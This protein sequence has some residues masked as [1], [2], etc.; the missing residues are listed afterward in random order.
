MHVER[1]NAGPLMV[2]ELPDGSRVIVDRTNETVFALNAMAAAAWDACSAP[3]T[4]AN[5]TDSMR[6][7]FDPLTTEELAQEAIFQLREKNLVK[8]SASFPQS[9]RRKFIATLGAAAVPLV[10]SL[11]IADQR[12][13]ATVASSA[14]PKP[15]PSVKPCSWN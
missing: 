6:R 5:V 15:C 13:H 14:K 10:V 12:A 3:T 7:S 2:N 9:T 1:L 4:L 11:T 8:T